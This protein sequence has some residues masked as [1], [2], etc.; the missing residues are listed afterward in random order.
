MSSF[1]LSFVIVYAI[2]APHPRFEYSSTEFPLSLDRVLRLALSLSLLSVHSIVNSFIF[3]KLYLK[4]KPA[5]NPY[6]P[7]TLSRTFLDNP[8]LEIL[9]SVFGPAL[10][11]PHPS[12]GPGTEIG[13]EE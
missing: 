11:L 7:P 1:V 10:L 12:S 5:G 13:I 8:L 9:L 2:M 4:S 3:I 6:I